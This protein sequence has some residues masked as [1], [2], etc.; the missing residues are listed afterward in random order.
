[1]ISHITSST[2]SDKEP[3]LAEYQALLGTTAGDI[4]NWGFFVESGGGGKTTTFLTYK[5]ANAGALTDYHSVA[6]EA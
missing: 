4:G 5:K 1:M 6:M 3:T 2:P